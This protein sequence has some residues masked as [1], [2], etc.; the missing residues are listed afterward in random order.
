M[1]NGHA[2]NG[3]A[4]NGHVNP[5]ERRRLRQAEEFELDGLISDEED[6][7]ELGDVDSEDRDSGHGRMKERS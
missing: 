3:R 6:A 4:V 2:M 7:R 1:L 5:E